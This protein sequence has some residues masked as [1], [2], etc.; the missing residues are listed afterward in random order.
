MT[1]RL[2]V[3][4][5]PSSREHCAPAYH[6]ERPERLDAALRGLERVACERQA[7]PIRAASVDELLTV[8]GAAFVEQMMALEAPTSAQH[9]ARAAFLD[10]DTFVVDGSIA[11]ARRA[12]GAGLETVAAL[13]RGEGTRGVVLVRPPGHH[14]RREQA[15]GFCLFNNVALMAQA[16][17]AQGFER[18][19]IVDFDVHHGNGTQEIFYERPDVLYLSTHQYP[20]FPGTGA[21]HERGAKDGTGFTV[22]VPLTGGADD[23]VY[24]ASFSR[25]IVP[26]L[27]SY[28][29]D[30]LL[31]SAGFD[32]ALHDPLAEMRLSADAY[33][34]MMR[35]LTAVAERSAQGRI[36]MVLEGGYD[37]PSLEACLAAAL[38][39]MLEPGT[40]QARP[41][42]DCLDLKLAEQAARTHWP[43]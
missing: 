19:A 41:T 8:H 43:V 2:L 18:V 34:S 26:V 36:A 3:A 38:E 30:L 5:D 22:N 21:L 6:P 25:V 31:V 39:G 15:M 10:P 35:A 23:S 27:E 40:E 12:A 32:A 20:L 11:A 42:S 7:V 29:P 16:A 28:A 1:S 37:L 33:R 4:H 14:A 17:R 13:V 9:E 24:H